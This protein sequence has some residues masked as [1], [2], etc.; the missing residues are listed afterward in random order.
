MGRRSHGSFV[1]DDNIYTFLKLPINPLVQE[2]NLL[3]R[4]LVN[5]R[6]AQSNNWRVLIPE[7]HT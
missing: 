2:Y 4:V 5:H 3:G 7:I 6:T 1:S